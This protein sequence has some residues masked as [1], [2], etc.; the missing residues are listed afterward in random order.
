MISWIRDLR[1]RLRQLQTLLP[2][3]RR[4][5]Y[6]VAALMCL[7][8]AFE[9]ISVAS[10]AP[11]L[12]VA[13]DPGIID[14]VPVLRWAYQAGAFTSTGTFTIALAAVVVA[15]LALGNGI[16]ALALHRSLTYAADVNHYLSSRL[17]AGYLAQP[18]AFH[19][20]EHSAGLQKNVLLESEVVSASVLQPLL[21]V[22]GQAIVILVVTAS[23][24]A[25]SPKAAV[26]VILSLCGAFMLTYGL[27]RRY[28][29]RFGRD[30]AE[31]N[32]DRSRITND[33]FAG[34]KELKILQ[35]EQ[36]PLERF[37]GPSRKLGRAKAMLG[38]LPVLPRYVIEALAVTSMIVVIVL[39]MQQGDPLTT[40]LP[41]ISMFLFG[42]FRLLPAL[43][44]LLAGA[45]SYSANKEIVGEVLRDLRTG[46]AAQ[47]SEMLD[48]SPLLFRNTI[49]F[50]SVTFT[51]GP[52]ALPVLDG[53][54]LTV[55][56]GSSVGLV[57]SSGSGKTTLADLLVGLYWPSSGRTC[58]DGIP[59]TPDNVRAW[60]RHISYVS[61]HVFL[62]D[63][64]ILQN[65]AFGQ[66]PE[67]VNRE[68]AWDALR[69][70]Q[71]EAFVKSLPDAIETRIGERGVR[72]SGGQRQRLGIARALYLRTPVLILDEATSALDVETERALMNQIMTGRSDQTLIV[73][74]HRLSTIRSCD[75][76]VVLDRGS[77]ADIGT[78]DELVAR[79]DRFLE[80]ARLSGAHTSLER[81]EA[82]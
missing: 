4:Q 45:A 59:I 7:R 54:S 43:Q 64:T 50:D 53:I 29:D 31:A 32:R 52:D 61:Q 80:L 73:I 75:Q 60:R 65:I 24:I 62:S 35:C 3:D 22:L 20:R 15:A 49:V 56:R 58:V 27:I 66:R 70:A 18:Y 55:P 14:R 40:V 81:T 37:N 57:G 23:L 68:Q 12:Q 71:L 78:W 19:T 36:V 46:Q 1:H 77:V 79:N 11:F 51:Y 38:S 34:I 6:I 17:L 69:K 5:L 67:H 63:D 25:T 26:V 16:A 30:R 41:T 48:P 9:F 13:S 28:V 82:V 10:I 33:A 44:G 76:I 8:G 42:G 2:P 47:A 74:A 72:L 39:R 21:N